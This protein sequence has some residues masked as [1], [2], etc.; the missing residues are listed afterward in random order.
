MGGPSAPRT[1]EQ[2]AKSIIWLATIGNDGPNGE[3]F[4]DGER[5]D[6]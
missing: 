4:R 5:I 3:F 2:A 6:W 1:P